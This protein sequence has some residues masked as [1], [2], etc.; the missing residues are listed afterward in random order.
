[1]IFSEREYIFNHTLS[2]VRPQAPTSWL[3]K[4]QNNKKKKT[5][6]RKAFKSLNQNKIKKKAPTANK[7]QQIKLLAP[8]ECDAQPNEL[9]ELLSRLTKKKPKKE[10]NIF[11]T[12]SNARP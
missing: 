8:C 7:S 10:K 5:R 9:K 2:F 6:R 3:N 12:T 4:K 11:A 1:M